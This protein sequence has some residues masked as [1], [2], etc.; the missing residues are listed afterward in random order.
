MLDNDVG[1]DEPVKPV[2]SE[3]YW[4]KRKLVESLREFLAASRR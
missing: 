3:L 2:Y 4:K 1:D